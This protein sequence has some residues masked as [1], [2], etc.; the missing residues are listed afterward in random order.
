MPKEFKELKLRAID[1]ERLGFQI[2]FVISDDEA[3]LKECKDNARKIKKKF[4]PDPI[5][6]SGPCLICG[7]HA[8]QLRGDGYGPSVF[9][10]YGPGCI[11][12]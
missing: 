4:F 8:T 9:C 2:S 11:P 12:F 6:T 5:P 10:C 3:V 7:E 1:C